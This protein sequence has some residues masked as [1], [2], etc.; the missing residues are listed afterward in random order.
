[1]R[2]AAVSA[3]TVIRRLGGTLNSS[4]AVQVPSN[5]SSGQQPVGAFTVETLPNTAGIDSSDP[6]A[7]TNEVV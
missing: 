1:M 5:P 3:V 7:G 2:K 4:S 6:S